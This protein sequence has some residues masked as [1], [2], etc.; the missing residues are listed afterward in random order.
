MLTHLLDP[1]NISGHRDDPLA[2]EKQKDRLE[3]A[4]CF[5]TWAACAEGLRRELGGGSGAGMRAIATELELM[6]A[7]AA[8]ADARLV[9]ACYEGN[10]TGVQ[11]ALRSGGRV[12]SVSTDGFTPLLA[13]LNHGAF[14]G[15]R[16][17]GGS[18]LTAELVTLLLELGADVNAAN[19]NGT[20]PLMLSTA[21]ADQSVV[22]LLVAAG[23]DVNARATK[24]GKRSTALHY[25]ASQ[26]GCTE[27][28]RRRTAR[29]LLEA[30]A[31]FSLDASGAS[32]LGLA[33]SWHHWGMAAELLPHAAAAHATVSPDLSADLRILHHTL[34]APQTTGEAQKVLL[35]A[36]LKLW[37]AANPGVH[38]PSDL[39][40]F[41]ARLPALTPRE[42]WV[43]KNAASDAGD[44]L[45]IALFS[46]MIGACGWFAGLFTWQQLRAFQRRCRALVGTLREALCHL[47]LH[48]LMAVP[49]LR[50]LV[51][52]AAISFALEGSKYICHLLTGPESS[53]ARLVA[54]AIVFVQE[55]PSALFCTACLAI[56]IAVG[57]VRIAAAIRASEAVASSLAALRPVTPPPP[58]PPPPQ[59]P[60][61]TSAAA[62]V[63]Q[64]ALSRAERR[65]IAH[66]EALAAATAAAAANI[67]A[68]PLPQPIE[69]DAVPVEPPIT[70]ATAPAPI[71]APPS[72][73]P[74]QPAPPPPTPLPQ[75]VPLP[76]PPPP[77]P[78]A[79][80]PAPIALPPPAAAP[81]P[82]PPQAEAPLTEAE[83]CVC[84]EEYSLN[85]LCVFRPSCR[86]PPNLCAACL[87][88]GA[89][90]S[91]PMR[92]QEAA[93]G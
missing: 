62:P 27:D 23:A 60:A 76:P 49:V 11:S 33:L 28:S 35:P 55:P 17:S 87:S 40:E 86:H 57:A 48:P 82:L 29:L 58:P 14:A 67:L 25:L 18:S 54:R 73:P 90:R 39:G 26:D 20:T 91:C 64:A 3:R 74:L 30:G 75:P 15:A 71:A 24:A 34:Y 61:T 89:V 31:N 84:L 36:I 7:D 70:P 37:G 45:M 41:W 38:H 8:A 63:R 42:L 12:N 46:L 93:A 21:L 79:P 44:T 66:A 65:R 85:A 5:R 68:A 13:A 4:G 92:C 22:G 9:D 80:L 78:P 69:E 77:P 72:S 32:P 10:M 53:A 81:H 1:D 50:V 88:T 16:S 2:H 6:D 51:A 59:P 83:C 52:L 47:L 43:K 56:D 19:V